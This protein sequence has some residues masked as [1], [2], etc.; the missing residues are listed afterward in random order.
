VS[1]L[2]DSG[3]EFAAIFISGYTE[4]GTLGN[5]KLENETILLSTV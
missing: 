1:K 4:I 3:R 2:E 5:A